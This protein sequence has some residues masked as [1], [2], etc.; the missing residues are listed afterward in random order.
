M[1]PG[2]EVRLRAAV[3]DDAARIRCVV[4]AAYS[5][6]RA[7]LDHDPAPL[8]ADY[9]DL[10]ARGRVTV[11]C[12]AGD[13]VGVLVTVPHAEHLL[14]ENVA[15]D[16]AVQGRGVGAVLLE[17]AAIEARARGLRELRLYTNAAMRENLVYY[18]RRGYVETGLR[19]E[20]GFE[21]VFF[22]RTLG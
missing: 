2:T 10:V 6:Y 4:V 18:P 5:P 1:L 20:D 12:R 11:A 16:P 8:A 19:T 14:V 22:T 17:R 15:V 9:G 13:V 21:R 3:A 7:R